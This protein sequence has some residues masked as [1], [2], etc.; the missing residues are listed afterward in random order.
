LQSFYKK[1]KIRFDEDP[2]FK[3]RAQKAVVLLQVCVMLFVACSLLSRDLSLL[4]FKDG[5]KNL[6]MVFFFFELNALKMPV[7]FSYF[8]VGHIGRFNS[9]LHDF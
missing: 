9:E 4:S 3:E 6:E 1:A 5:W 2:A 7:F 8:P